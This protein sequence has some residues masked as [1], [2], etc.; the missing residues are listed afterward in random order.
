MWHWASFLDRDPEHEEVDNR[1][2]HQ[3]TRATGLDHLDGRAQE[4][5]MV[6]SRSSTW[7]PFASF[8]V[9][10]GLGES[11]T[12]RVRAGQWYGEGFNKWR[13]I[14][15]WPHE[16]VLSIVRSHERAQPALHPAFGGVP[17]A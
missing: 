6:V 7:L 11:Q 9:H 2:R 8:R 3:E 15:L 4:L 13:R 12:G 17:V 16:E 1:S 14:T 5:Q 10:V